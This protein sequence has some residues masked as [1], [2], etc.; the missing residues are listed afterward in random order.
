MVWIVH[1]SLVQQCRVAGILL[2]AGADANQRF[3]IPKTNGFTPLHHAAR[4][5]NCELAGVLLVGGADVNAMDAV[6]ART[7]AAAA[8]GRL[9]DGQNGC[10]PVQHANKETMKNLLREAGAR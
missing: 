4:R 3:H 2:A 1:S 5:N 10:T 9:L 7:L 6:T 8:D